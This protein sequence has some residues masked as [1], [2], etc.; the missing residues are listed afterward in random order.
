MNHPNHPPTKNNSETKAY[1]ISLSQAYDH[2][3]FITRVC[4][5]LKNESWVNCAPHIQLMLVY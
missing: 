1:Q 2:K 4:W 5:E 3:V